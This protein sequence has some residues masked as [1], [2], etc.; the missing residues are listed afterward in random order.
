MHYRN[1]AFSKNGEP[2]LM[3]RRFPGLKF[4]QRKMFSRG[5][6]D[7]INKLYDC[8]IKRNDNGFLSKFFHQPRTFN[9]GD[10]IPNKFDE[11]PDES[12]WFNF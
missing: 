11:T 10:L 2:T 5:D 1:T 9:D 8:K 3:S 12:S 6:I 4:G 7:Q